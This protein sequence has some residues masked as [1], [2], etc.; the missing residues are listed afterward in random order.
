MA[1]DHGFPRDNTNQIFTE[2]K[3]NTEVKVSDQ[4]FEA[5]KGSPRYNWKEGRRKG[6]IDIGYA[7]DCYVNPKDED[8]ERLCSC[9]GDPGKSSNSLCFKRGENWVRVGTA[10]HL[11]IDWINA[12]GS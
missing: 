7:I 2:A 8:D 12:V 10:K 1:T 5:W 4:I 6:F 11:W 3:L 9:M